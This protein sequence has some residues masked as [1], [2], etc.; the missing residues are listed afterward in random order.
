MKHVIYILIIVFL[1]S[2][3]MK[4]VAPG[5]EEA[6]S[7][8]DDNRSELLRVLR[9][10]EESGDSLK[11]RA[12]AFLIGNMA[13]KGYLTG[14]AID[15]YYA[16]IDS[17]YQIKQEEY[18]IPYI[19][20]TFRQQAQYLKKKPVLHWDVQNLSADYLIRNIDEAFAVWNCPW[21]QHLTFEEFCEWVLPYRVGDRN[22]GSMANAVP[23]TV[24]TTVDE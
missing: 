16:F 20:E 9:H 3:Q 21:N 15:E 4:S 10:Y 12:A 11:L 13:D 2:C 17:V 24:R 14:A 6:F 23:R 18:D 8:A 1:V 7:K 22:P 19:Y 5:S